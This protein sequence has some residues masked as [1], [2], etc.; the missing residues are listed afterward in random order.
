MLFTKPQS[1]VN[2]PAQI[3]GTGCGFPALSVEKGTRMA[4][5]TDGNARRGVECDVQSA[6][7]GSGVERGRLARSYF[8]STPK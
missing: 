4:P 6:A 5:S 2:L 7:V 8:E 1:R 3:Q